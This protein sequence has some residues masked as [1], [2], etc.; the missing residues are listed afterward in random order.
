ML[1][2]NLLLSNPITCAYSTHHAFKCMPSSAL[3]IKQVAVPKVLDVLRKGLLA[4][5]KA[6]PSKAKRIL[7]DAALAARENSKNQG[8]SSPLFDAL[9]FK[10]VLIKPYSEVFRHSS[11]YH[12]AT[13]NHLKPDILSRRSARRSVG[14]CA[15]SSRGVPH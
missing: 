8:R 15:S 2:W 7:F 9:I 4:K 11:E 14:G 10:K 6:A 5:V 12:L 13:T 1:Q 3:R